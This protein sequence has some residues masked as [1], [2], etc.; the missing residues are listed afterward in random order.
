MFNVHDILFNLKF[1]PWSKEEE[2]WLRNSEEEKDREKPDRKCLPLN[3]TWIVD[4]FIWMK[5]ENDKEKE[6]GMIGVN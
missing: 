2:K 1:V 6:K 4:Q 3:C 5:R